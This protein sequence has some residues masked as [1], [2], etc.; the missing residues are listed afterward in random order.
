[1]KKNKPWVKAVENALRA[2]GFTKGAARK[3]AAATVSKSIAK[4]KLV[5]ARREHAVD[6]KET[7]NAHRIRISAGAREAQRLHDAAAINIPSPMAGKVVVVPPRPMN[8]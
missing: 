3:T 8:Q 6:W 2:K 4:A 1:M 5:A 7:M